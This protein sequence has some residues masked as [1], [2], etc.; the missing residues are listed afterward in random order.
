MK[1]T[2]EK[3]NKGWFNIEILLITIP[4]YAHLII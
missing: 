4:E 3:S 1:D 2:F